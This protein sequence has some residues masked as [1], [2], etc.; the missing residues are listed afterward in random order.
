MGRSNE[1]AIVKRSKAGLGLFA[2]AEIPKG[3]KIVEYT[4]EIISN[5]DDDLIDGKYLF[6]L[7]DEYTIDGRSRENLGRYVNHSCRPNASAVVLGGEAWIVARRK[8]KPG[9]EI[10]FDYGKAYFEQHIAPK[11]CKCVKCA[12]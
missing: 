7:N 9:E 4:G 10:A 11:G 5:E 2:V 1:L 12:P 3:T 6:D 8:I